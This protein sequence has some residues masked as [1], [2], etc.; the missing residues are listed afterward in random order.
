MHVSSGARLAF[1]VALAA[2]LATAAVAPTVA[3]PW[4]GPAP[5]PAPAAAHPQIDATA[6]PAPNETG[7][8]E[9]PERFEAWLDG[10]MATSMEAHDVPGATVSVVTDDGLYHAEGYGRADVANG[11]PVRADATAFRVGSVSKLVVWT[12]V[13]QGVEDGRLALD[14]D[15]NAYLGDDLRVPDTY[16]EPVTLGHLGT[17]SA[18]F[19]DVYERVFVPNASDVGPLDEELRRTRPARVAPPGAVTAYSNWGAA[20]AGHVAARSADAPSFAAHAD[21]RIF[22][23]LGMRNST[24]QQPMPPALADRM[25]TGYQPGAGRQQPQTFEVIAIPPAGSMTA[26]ATDVARFMR[27]HLGDG[28]LAGP[29]NATGDAPRN[30]SGPGPGAATATANVTRDPTR[31]LEPATV[32]RMQRHRR[33]DHPAVNGWAYGFYEVDRN[34]ERVLAHAGDT[35]DFHSLLFLLPERD[36][37]VFVSYNGPGGTVARNHLY[38]AF[39]DRYYP[40]DGEAAPAEPTGDV[41]PAVEGTYRTTRM[42]HTDWY[43]VL[44][45]FATLSVRR[46][47]DGTLL[48]TRALGSDATR[49]VREDDLVY[50]ERDGPGTL[51]FE[52]GPDGAVTAAYRDGDF[53]EA[54]TALPPW[55]SPPLHGVALVLALLVF[56]STLALWPYTVYRDRRTG[57]PIRKTGGMKLA[58]L[59]GAALAAL[60]V[61]FVAAGAA[62]IA[63]PPGVLHGTPPLLERLGLVPELIAG[64]A[65]LVALFAVHAWYRGRWTR[66]GRI[67]YGLLALSGAAF[68]GLLLFYNLF[69]L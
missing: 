56:L 5:P 11:T 59:A 47:G 3:A 8:P 62:A 68:T 65:G 44:S 17:H 31:I 60:A 20:L 49:W 50:G 21:D 46:V 22:T 27:A 15:V 2:A 23:P 38:H 48:T 19:E 13:M 64:L 55:A 54:F 45:P 12:A 61:G 42:S 16:D 32:E 24:F 53:V 26:T 18:G 25:A 66:W 41:D 43:K 4:S 14:R 51:A 28:S 34:G 10:A 63:T 36:V 57:R 35:R 29:A 69:A 7:L 1:A 30:L 40:A 58:R 33:S 6:P 67:H 39:V 37:G 52:R 9:D